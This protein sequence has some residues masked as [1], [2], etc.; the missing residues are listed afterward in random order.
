MSILSGHFDKTYELELDVSGNGI[1][2]E[3]AFGERLNQIYDL[4]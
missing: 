3:E 1:V 2:N 4:F